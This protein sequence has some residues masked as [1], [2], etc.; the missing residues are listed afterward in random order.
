[1]N[2]DPQLD[3]PIY[4]LQSPQPS[5]KAQVFFEGETSKLVTIPGDAGNHNAIS[6]F[7]FIHKCLLP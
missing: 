5:P 7:K 4:N 3:A 6:I 2:D 1:M